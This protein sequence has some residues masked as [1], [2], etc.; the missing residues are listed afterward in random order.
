ML[1]VVFGWDN[2]IDSLVRDERECFLLNML[3]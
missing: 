2:D 3:Q 1:S